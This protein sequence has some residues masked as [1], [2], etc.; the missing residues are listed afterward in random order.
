MWKTTIV[1]LINKGN[2]KHCEMCSNQ[3]CWDFDDVT[4]L[5]IGDG[6]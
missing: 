2:F 4:I 1:T 5:Q 6:G 3:S